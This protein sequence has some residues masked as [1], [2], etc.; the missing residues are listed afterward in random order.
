MGAVY[1]PARRI[2]EDLSKA[3]YQQVSRFGNSRPPR[4]Y[5]PRSGAMLCAVRDRN[6]P[7]QRFNQLSDSPIDIPDFKR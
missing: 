3:T 1:R 4:C 6:Q 2:S 5:F 7:I